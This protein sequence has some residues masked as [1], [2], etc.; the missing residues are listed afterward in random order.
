MVLVWSIAACLSLGE[1]QTRASVAFVA[2]LLYI[3]SPAG[4]F[5][6]APYS[7]SPFAALNLLG[8]RLFLLGRGYNLRGEATAAAL[9]TISGG[10]A[11]GLATVVRSNGVLNGMLYAW[12]AVTS[13]LDLTGGER[14]PRQI[15]G[16][17]SLGLGG[18]LI[19]GGMLFPQYQ[20][21]REYCT[22]SQVED[23]RPWCHNYPPSIFTFVQSHYW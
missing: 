1:H 23:V 3:V 17:I 12:N 22:G 7:E 10:L 9:V 14:G 5:L 16:L 18:A 11:S 4:V 8:L 19:A 20:A 21:Y 15:V 13:L 6:S 2:A